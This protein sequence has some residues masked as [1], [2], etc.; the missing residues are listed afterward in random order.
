[1]GQHKTADLRADGE[2]GGGAAAFFVRRGYL[3]A[4]RRFELQVL[5]IWAIMN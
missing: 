5:R 2:S 4:R 3:A 1:M